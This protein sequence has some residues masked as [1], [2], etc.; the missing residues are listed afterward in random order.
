MSQRPHF[1]A[2][3][4]GFTEIA[5][6]VAIANPLVA[7]ADETEGREIHGEAPTDLLCEECSK[8]IATMYSEVDDELLCHHCCSL[9]YLPTSGGMQHEHIRSGQVRHLTG[10]DR[11]RLYSKVVKTVGDVSVVIPEFEVSEE[12]MAEIRGFAPDKP[13]AIEAPDINLVSESAAEE[14]NHEDSKFDKGDVVIFDADE[15]VSE[16]ENEKQGHAMWRGKQLLGIVLAVP[17][18]RHGAFGTAHR[19]IA[20][21]E[22]MY[23]VKVR[24]HAYEERKTRVGAI[25]GRGAKDGRANRRANTRSLVAG[26]P[27]RDGRVRKVSRQGGDAGLG[28][29][30]TEGRRGEDSDEFRDLG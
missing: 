13:S 10:F 30:D 21:N 11:D 3:A 29:R 12:E 28:W 4:G 25:P 20:G 16:E 1:Q 23:R 15:L 2:G 26:R 18:A 14:L 19:R 9:L 24:A 6:G 17:N 8:N 7:A 5:P 27:L 22:M